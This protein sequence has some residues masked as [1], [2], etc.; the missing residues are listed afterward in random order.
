MKVTVT[1]RGTEY[2]RQMLYD[3]W[4]LSRTR[5]VSKPLPIPRPRRGLSL[6][7]LHS[8]IKEQKPTDTELLGSL[9][10]AMIAANPPR[11]VAVRNPRVAVSPEFKPRYASARGSNV[12]NEDLMLLAARERLKSQ[13]ELRTTRSRISSGTLT[14]MSVDRVAQE[15]LYKSMQR[16]RQEQT[17]F[18][19][20]QMEHEATTMVAKTLKRGKLAVVLEEIRRKRE[21]QERRRKEIVQRFELEDFVAFND[22]ARDIEKLPR[23]EEMVKSTFRERFRERLRMKH[24]NMVNEWKKKTRLLA[25]SEPAT[26]RALAPHGK[27]SEGAA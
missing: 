7:L 15:R 16:F 18:R 17:P 25:L 11:E 26:R 20:R 19:L 2:M 3:S 27:A 14:A 13:L 4:T 23:K 1:E 10:P 5:T 21:E 9:L 8:A 12:L 22:K 6:V 24:M